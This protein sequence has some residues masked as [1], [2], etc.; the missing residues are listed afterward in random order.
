[1]KL[2]HFFS[3][4]FLFIGVS[5]IFGQS[6]V[7]NSNFVE[8]TINN[9]NSAV[10][11]NNSNSV[12]DL[13]KIVGSPYENETF[14]LG[15]AV[16][17]LTKKSIPFYLRYN[18]YN[19]IIEID[20]N[21][22]TFG[23]IKSQNIYAIINN[24]EYHY[25]TYLNDNAKADEGYFI[26]MS[27]GLH[28]NLYLRKSKEFKD[29]VKSKDSFHKETPA[30]FIDLKSY[31]IKKDKTLLPVSTKKKEFLFQFP[32]KENE[33]KKYMKAEKINLKSE[34]DV[35]KLFTYYDSLLK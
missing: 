15:K 21:Q 26:L 14:S 28:S 32:E 8:S 4:T 3:L 6:S 23:L 13:S 29:K 2:R 27:K 12:I 17:K 34:K 9:L 18:I 11:L 20:D 25:E 7:Q 10:K 24:T 16:N 30:S 19:D 5:V 22:N 1:M 31:Y 33:L 35:V